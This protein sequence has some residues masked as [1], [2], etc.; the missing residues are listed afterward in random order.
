MECNKLGFQ[1]RSQFSL[2]SSFNKWDQSRSP[3]L[4]RSGEP[5]AVIMTDFSCSVDL[6]DRTQ[7]Q[8][9]ILRGL[10]ETSRCDWIRIR[11][12]R[13]CDCID[14]G[15]GWVIDK[16]GSETI[17]IEGNLDCQEIKH[18]LSFDFGCLRW[19]LRGRGHSPKVPVWFCVVAQI[20][21]EIGSRFLCSYHIGWLHLQLC[22]GAGFTI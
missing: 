5:R 6:G 20:E 4:R 17:Q 7:I 13:I 18:D 3:I 21:R 22:T 2:V 19:S 12:V 15:L 10:V 1:L 9:R 11:K 8:G 16:G 14:E